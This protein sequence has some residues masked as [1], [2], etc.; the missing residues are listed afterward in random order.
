VGDVNRGLL[1]GAASSSAKRAAGAADFGV[2]RVEGAAGVSV[3]RLCPNRL[4]PIIKVAAV[5]APS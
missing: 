3:K 4:K 2:K 1:V 5:M